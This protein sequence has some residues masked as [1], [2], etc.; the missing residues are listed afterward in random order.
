MA[1]QVIRNKWGIPTIIIRE[2]VKYLGVVRA[3]MLPAEW[4]H[5]DYLRYY[6]HYTERERNR[7]TVCEAE[8]MLMTAGRTQILTQ[9]FGTAPAAFGLYFA[10]GTGVISNVTPGDGSLATESFRAATST[11]VVT[12][13]QID[14]STF[15]GALQA[16]STYTNAGLWGGSSATGSLGTGTLEAHM[17]YALTKT[18]ANSLTNDYLI[19]LL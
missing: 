11:G 16:N 3:R 18:S 10:V 7:L 17:L 15:F 5:E 12:G 13:N 14:I 9:L 1:L 4:T 19:Q 8:N 6:P 2:R